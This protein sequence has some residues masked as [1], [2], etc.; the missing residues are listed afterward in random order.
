MT[1]TIPAHIFWQDVPG[2]L[3]VFDSENES[4]HALNGSA[5]AIWREIA[6][7]ADEATAA[8]RL[9]ETYGAP[10]VEIDEDVAA[11]VADALAKGLL[12]REPV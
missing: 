1:L 2:E 9:A 10:R 11:F 3:A 7:G 6:G 4:Y 12:V 8:A 5:A